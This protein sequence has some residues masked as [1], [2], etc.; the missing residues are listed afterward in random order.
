MNG[1]DGDRVP[2][3][4]DDRPV[5]LTDERFGLLPEQTVDDTDL[6]WG[7]GPSSN[8][9]RLIADRPPHWD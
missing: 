4:D 6:G 5:D 7:D 3:R 1:V 8:D 2:A 9:D